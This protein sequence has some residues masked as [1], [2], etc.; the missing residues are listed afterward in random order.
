MAELS[1]YPPNRQPQDALVVRQQAEPDHAIVPYAASSISRAKA[2]P[3]NPFRDE[4]SAQKRKNV[5]TGHAEET[6]LSEHTFRSKHRAVERRGGPER[7]QQSS[8]ALKKEAARIRAGREAKGDATISEGAGAYVG[9][10]AKYS[11]AE[12]EKVGSDQEIGSDDEYET[13]EE[14]VIESGTVVTAPAMAMARRKEIEELGDETTTF[15]GSS[16]FDYQGRTYMH[17][18]QDLGIDLHKETGSITNYIPKKQIHAWKD[19]DKAVTALRFLPNS[20]HLLLSASADTTVRIR[21]VFHD[22]ELLRTYHGHSKAVSDICFNSSGTQFLSASYDRMMKL[23]DTETGACIAKFTTGK[24]PHV[25]KFNPDPEHANEFLAGMSDKKI[26]QFDTR[27]PK[28]TVQEYDHHLAA[29]NT[30]TF[31]DQNRRFM[32]TSDDRSLRAW[33]YNIPVPIKYIA[34]PDMYPMTNAVL[35]PNKKYVAYQSSDNQILVYGANEK[36]RQNRKKCYRG[37]N[38]AGLAIELDCS[39]D[40]QF[41]VSGD[42]AGFVCFWDWKTCKMYHKLKAGTQAVT[43]VRWHPQE[44]SKVATAGLDGEIRYWD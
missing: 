14:E 22:R 19:H 41:L 24:T 26:V 21:D 20:G 40:G 1:E 17:V 42:S 5:L 10:W 34:E 29:I 44:S 38:N 27:T 12:Y 9:P 36:F 15:N 7:E 30:I 32:T 13:V 39:P 35:H 43:C 28:E 18:P 8:T 4:S 3:A 33:D 16:E 2:G 23:W 11:N 31:V 37:H 25:I 6:F